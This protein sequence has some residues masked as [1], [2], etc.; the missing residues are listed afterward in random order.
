M[1]SVPIPE[2]YL[3][4]GERWFGKGKIRLRTLLGSCVAIT[5]WHPG[6]NVGGMCHYLLPSDP[7]RGQNRSLDPRYADE[8]MLLFLKDIKR[9]KTCP[10]D[11]RAG[12]FGGGD[13]FATGKRPWSVD[14]GRR[15]A[16]MGRLLLRKHGFPLAYEDLEGRS[17]RQI[18]LDMRDGSL[19]L[20]RGTEHSMLLRV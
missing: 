19:V 14:I 15:N 20:R 18:I 7:G 9:C 17:H 3:Y 12:L 1:S 10:S 6:L 16:T 2:R 13:M 8:A 5:L 11:Y 4:P